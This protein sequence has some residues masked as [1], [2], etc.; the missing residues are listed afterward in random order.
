MFNDSNENGYSYWVA[1]SKDGIIYATIGL[2]IYDNVATQMGSIITI[3]ALKNKI[4]AQDFIHWELFKYA[5]SQGC[6]IYDVAGVNPNP[7]NR[8]EEG[9]REFKK[10]WGGEYTEYNIYHK[11]FGNLMPAIIE[12]A[13]YITRFA[14]ILSHR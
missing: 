14:K 6:H 12:K 5:K 1:Q 9:I 11:T 3:D 2:Y 10:K 7:E 13:K 4:P 8:K